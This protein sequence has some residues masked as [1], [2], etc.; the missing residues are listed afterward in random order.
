MDLPARRLLL[1]K[2][3]IFICYG[4]VGRLTRRAAVIEDVPP[5]LSVQQQQAEQMKVY[6]K[7]C[8]ANLSVRVVRIDDQCHLF[9]SLSKACLRTL[10]HSAWYAYKGC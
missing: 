4:V 7:V 1:D 9:D 8:D 10:V 3:C 2:V 5:I 6:W